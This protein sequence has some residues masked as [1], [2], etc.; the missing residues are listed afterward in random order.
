MQIFAL[1]SSNTEFLVP[2]AFRW[3]FVLMILAAVGVVVSNF[4]LLT[5]GM[6]TMRPAA[7]ALAVA[8]SPRQH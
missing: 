7:E 8:K 1:R 3:L 6:F 4:A 5:G 2:T